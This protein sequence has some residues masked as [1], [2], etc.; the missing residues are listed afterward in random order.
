MLPRSGDVLHVTRTA[1]VQFLRPIMFRVIRVH[2]WPTYDGWVWLDGYELNATG[3]AINRRSIFVQAAGL[4]QLPA[5]PAMRPNPVRTL[6][7]LARTP[8]RVG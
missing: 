6:R 4:R 5:T 2:D 8:V 7:P 3:D 1:S